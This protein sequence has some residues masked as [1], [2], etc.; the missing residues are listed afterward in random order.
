VQTPQTPNRN[1]RPLDVLRGP[2]CDACGKTAYPSTDAA[3]AEMR[4]QKARGGRAHRPPTHH[5]PCPIDKDRYHL[6]SRRLG[7]RKRSR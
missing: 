3:E 7:Q 4:R 5:Y 2:W 6:A 1:T